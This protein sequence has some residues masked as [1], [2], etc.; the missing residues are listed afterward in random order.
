MGDFRGFRL[1]HDP[2]QGLGAGGTD[3]NAALAV[4]LFLP[5]AGLLPETFVGHDAL[6]DTGRVGHIHVDELLGILGAAGSQPG[7]RNAAAA[8]SLQELQGRQLTVAG[9]GIFPENGVARLFA[10]DGKAVGEHLLQHMA[11]AH[12]GA[13]QVQAVLPA[14][15]VQ[16]QV[17]HHCGNNGVAGELPLTLQLGGAHGHDLVAVDGLAFFVHQQAAVGV[18]V[19]GNAQIIAA[20]DDALGQGL[21]VGR[22]AAVVDIDTVGLRMDEV[23]V[24]GQRTEQVR[25]QALAAP[26]AQSTSTRRPVRSQSML[27][28]RCRI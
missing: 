12:G 25:G 2:N 20:G 14:I 3:E 24:E 21:Q 4:Q 19:E 28:S 13:D 9:G 1:Y 11:V 6:L 17:G 15:F 18:A 23:G 5:A 16:T 26:L 22:A 7:G 27:P 8:Q 10:A